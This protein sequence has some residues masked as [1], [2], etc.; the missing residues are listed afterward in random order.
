[1]DI[2]KLHFHY[3][4]Q[5]EWTKDYRQLLYRKIS[6]TRFRKI[7]DFGCG[8]GV[9]SKELQKE[10][11]QK[12]TA[13]DRDREAI[14]FARQNFPEI[15]FFPG[16][17]NELLK[18]RQKFDLIFLH[19][20]LLWQPNPVQFLKKLCRLLTPAGKIVIAAEP[21]YGGRIDFPAEFD[22]LKEFFAQTISNQNG[23]PFI[24][25]KLKKILSETNLHSEIGVF[26]YL[27]FPQTFDRKTWLQEWQI[28]S[29][30]GRI[31]LDTTMKLIAKEEKAIRQR[32]RMV[33]FPIFYAIAENKQAI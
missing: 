12:I 29:E 7:L 25:R 1:M 24:G 32:Q 26:N 28:W 20:V 16:D 21:D 14:D 23:D 5:S 15:N 13:V 11:G 3:L 18:S 27:F 30:W 6:L 4:L 31:D 19:F 9:I 10:S 17:E 22:F 2:S 33:L 8:T